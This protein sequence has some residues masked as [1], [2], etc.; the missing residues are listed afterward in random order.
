MMFKFD[1]YVNNNIASIQC[2]RRYRGTFSIF[3]FNYIYYM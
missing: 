2:Q 3:S 1:V